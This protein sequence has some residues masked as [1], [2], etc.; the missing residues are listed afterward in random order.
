MLDLLISY[1]NF[2]IISL[3]HII[4]KL[5]FQ[6]PEPPGYILY[7]KKNEK[8]KDIYFLIENGIDKEIK[9]G[10]PNFKDAKIE[11]IQKN[12]EKNL[13]TDLLIIRPYYHFPICIIYCHGNCGDIGYCLY[14]CYLLAKNS[15]C[16]VLSFEYPNYGSLNNMQ[17]SEINTYKF[18]QIAYIYANKILKFN[19]KNILVYGFSLGTGIAFDLSC[20]AKFPIGGLILQSPYLSI[21]RIVYNINKSPFFDIFKNC[22]KAHKLKAKTLFIHGNMDDVIPY[23]HG[24]ILA[25]IIPKKYF[26]DFYTVDEGE[27]NNL[28]LKD[29]ENIFNKIREFI[30]FCCGINIE[31]LIK[32]D[33]KLDKFNHEYFKQLYKEKDKN[34]INQNT[35][36]KRSNNGIEITSSD[37][38]K[39]QCTLDKS[40]EKNKSNKRIIFKAINYNEK[41][42]KSKNFFINKDDSYTN[43]QSNYHLGNNEIINKENN[44]NSNSLNEQQMSQLVNIKEDND[45]EINK[46]ISEFNYYLLN[47]NSIENISKINAKSLSVFNQ[48]IKFYNEFKNNNINK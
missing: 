33:I 30:N 16:V 38:T 3:S 22:D 28:L 21:F 40:M 48:K 15:N 20:R 17:Y 19:E 39:S 42:N 13:N 27:H 24:R 9:Y 8:Q 25:N 46:K 7:N 29:K 31:K 14:E 37:E 34:N 2:S 1:I 44:S 43:L 32:N 41:K 11:F 45:N 12:K 36:I 35:N 4:K 26:Y 47:K 5:A 18:I 23:I 10:K 6:P